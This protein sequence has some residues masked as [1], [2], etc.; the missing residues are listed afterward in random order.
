MDLN[1]KFALTILRLRLYGEVKLKQCEVAEDAGIS[2]RYYSELEKGTK[3]PT[4]KTVE[5]IAQVH[6]LKTWQLLQMVENAD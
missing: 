2:T 1:T 3:C 4:L 5:Q 6:G